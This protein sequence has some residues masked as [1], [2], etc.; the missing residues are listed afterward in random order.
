MKWTYVQEGA[1][2]LAPQCV[3]EE[4]RGCG[5]GQTLLCA[6]RVT[7]LEQLRVC[8]YWTMYVCVCVFGVLGSR[9]LWAAVC[10]W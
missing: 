6:H 2:L 5:L 9:V 8:V 1:L 10:L 4:S 7:D 3:Y